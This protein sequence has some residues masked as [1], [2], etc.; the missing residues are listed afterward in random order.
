MVYVLACL[1]VYPM[2]YVNMPPT[3]CTICQ[4]VVQLNSKFL[5]HSILNMSFCLLT[6]ELDLVGTSKPNLV[7]SILKIFG[8]V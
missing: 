6:C 1:L 4:G 7:G 3:Y 8:M 5:I 2:N